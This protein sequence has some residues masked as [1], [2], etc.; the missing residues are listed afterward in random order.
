ML[1][2]ED[3]EDTGLKNVGTGTKTPVGGALGAMTV[4]VQTESLQEQSNNLEGIQQPSL[5]LTCRN[6]RMEERGVNQQGG[7]AADAFGI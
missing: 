5:K 1:E 6:K 4:E 2:E 7:A 3:D